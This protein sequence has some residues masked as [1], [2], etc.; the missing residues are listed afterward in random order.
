MSNWQFRLAVSD[1]A[2][3]FAK[4]AAE[5]PQIDQ[6]DLIAGMGRTN[7]TVLT[8]VAEK[9]GVA[10]AFAPVYLSAVLAHLGFNPNSRAS[11][12]LEAM[13]VLKDGFSAL[14]VQFGVRQIE[15][16]SMPDYGVAQW[17]MKHGFE[18]EP[19]SLFRLD[20]NCEMA[21]AS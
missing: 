7:P 9:D 18:Q 5:N 14:M 17:A 19:R 3:A 20:L 11:E 8:G 4:W 16:L 2:A 13:N 1:D 15:T 12:K 6:K 10:V 21:E